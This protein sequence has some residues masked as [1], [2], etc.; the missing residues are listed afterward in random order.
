[1]QSEP[2]AGVV[3]DP[4]RPGSANAVEPGRSG[5]SPFPL[6]RPRR[7]PPRAR[8]RGDPFQ[9]L[10]LAPPQRLGG[11]VGGLSPHPPGAQRFVAALGGSLSSCP[12]LAGGV[13]ARFHATVS[14]GWSFSCAATPTGAGFVGRGVHVQGSPAVCR[15]SHPGVGGAGAGRRPGH[16]LPGAVQAQLRETGGRLVSKTQYCPKPAVGRQNVMKPLR[17]S[18]CPDLISDLPESRLPC[19][20]GRAQARP[21]EP[22]PL[23]SG[24]CQGQCALAAQRTRRSLCG[25]PKVGLRPGSAPRLSLPS[26]PRKRSVPCFPGRQRGSTGPPVPACSRGGCRRETGTPQH[27]ALC[28]GSSAPP[29]P[30]TGWFQQACLSLWARP[31]RTATPP[32]GPEAGDVSVTSVC[33]QAR[34]PRGPLEFQTWVEQPE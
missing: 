5:L 32:H 12:A 13:H 2:W 24:G 8:G 27:V 26:A 16:S 11:S 28:M 33:F 22:T 34:A 21:G 1:M 20:G 18:H 19:D 14:V 30:T 29:F 3:W 6:V 15:G 9:R 7:A 4:V 25:G 31:V 23:S 10:E 17:E